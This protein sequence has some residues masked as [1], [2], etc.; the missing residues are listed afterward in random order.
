MT[1]HQI[2][3]RKKLDQQVLNKRLSKFDKQ[4]LKVSPE[5]VARYF[6]GSN[7]KLPDAMKETVS[8]S[9]DDCLEKINPAFIYSL[10]KVKEL[11]SDYRVILENE[12]T[13][14][15]PEREFDSETKYLAVGVCSLCA[16]IENSDNSDMFKY[17]LLDAVG[18]SL[19]ESF[20]DKCF[21]IIKDLAN[22]MELFT[23]CR[24]GP[25]YGNMPIESQADIFNLLDAESIDVKLNETMVMSP[26]KTLSFF[27]NFTTN[28]MSSKSSY[29]CQNCGYVNCQFR[30]SA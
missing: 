22:S 25:G 11:T 24:F 15:I 12:I 9:I 5:H 4:E 20:G 16:D 2:D 14:T 8:K 29:K 3:W 30:I 7:Y 28:D 6:G 26:T 21:E 13:L 19:I 23:G 1:V 27:V 17:M 18:V 10:Y